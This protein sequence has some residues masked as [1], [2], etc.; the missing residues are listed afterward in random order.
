M[1][2][3]HYLR[4]ELMVTM[5]VKTSKQ[6]ETY[7]LRLIIRYLLVKKIF[8]WRNN[9]GATFDP[10]TR[11]F[12]RPSIGAKNGISDILGCLQCG[13]ILAIEVKTPEKHRY[14]KKHYDEL[15]Y[16]VFDPK[17]PSEKKRLQ[18]QIIFI[19]NVLR[20]GGHAGFASSLED[21]DYILRQAPI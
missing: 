19:E 8:I 4:L 21:V 17:K 5:T 6:S 11:G 9:N 3:A 7:I 2:S 15:R 13:K 10:T 1:A 16:G 12:R 18:D 20:C 14:I